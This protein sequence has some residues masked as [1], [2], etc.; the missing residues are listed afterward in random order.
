M[1]GKSTALEDRDGLPD[2]IRIL[3]EKYPRDLWEGHSNFDGMTQ[4]WLSRHLEF[5]RALT[6]MRT[7]AQT[8]LDDR[9]DRS[10]TSRRMLH[11]G[12]FFIDA[13]HGHHNIEDHHYFPVLSKT[14]PRLERGFELLD[15]D[16][17]DLHAHLDDLAE[18]MS[19]IATTE[20]SLALR[21]MVGSTE[22][23]LGRFERF[24]DRHLTDEEDLVVPIVLEHGPIIV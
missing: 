6:M 24:M 22:T 13:L 4:F 15:A 10:N 7:D 14:E 3:I 23:A 19:Q 2:A 18:H 17:H 8:I 9:E 16:H 1:A 12:H 5:R 11:V 20:N 21:D